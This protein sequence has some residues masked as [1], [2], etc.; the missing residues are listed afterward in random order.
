MKTSKYPPITS[1]LIALSVV[2]VLAFLA[3]PSNAQATDLTGSWNSSIGLVYDITQNG[4]AITWE[5]TTTPQ[6]ATGT[7]RGDTVDAT[8]QG[9]RGSESATGSIIRDPQGRAVRIEWNNG[10][11]FNRQLTSMVVPDTL[12]TDPLAPVPDL[13]E[14]SDLEWVEDIVV[15]FPAQRNDM[16]DWCWKERFKQCQTWRDSGGAPPMPPM[17]QE[18]APLLILDPCMVSMAGN[19]VVI[20]CPPEFRDGI[21]CWKCVK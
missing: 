21:T 12:R 10:V 3:F 13:A 2:A 9:P 15:G 17:S 4:Q 20:K 11:M 18:C 7:V 6:T 5:V 16:E 14:W 1:G 8:W 19:C